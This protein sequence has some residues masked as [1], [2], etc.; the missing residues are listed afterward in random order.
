MGCADAVMDLRSALYGFDT[1]GCVFGGGV[2]ER[3]KIPMV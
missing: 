3:L 1:R 2:V